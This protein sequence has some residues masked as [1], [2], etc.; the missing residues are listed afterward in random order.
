MADLEEAVRRAIERV[1]RDTESAKEW[2]EDATDP[3]RERAER[4]KE[5]I[6]EQ[7]EPV[8]ERVDDIVDDIVEE[9][10][11][12]YHDIGVPAPWE[13]PEIVRDWLRRSDLGDELEKL[14]DILDLPPP[15]E[16]DE[17]D[18]D[19]E[20]DDDDWDIFDWLVLAWLLDELIEWLE[21][22]HDLFSIDV[23]FVVFTWEPDPPEDEEETVIEVKR[24]F[25]FAPVP[26]AARLLDPM[27]HGGVAFPG[28]GS[29]DVLIGGLPALRMIDQIACPMQ[30][31]IPHT[32]SVFVP[33]IQQVF[34][35]GLPALRAGD[36]MV[37]GLGGPNPIVTGC[38]TVIIGQPVP[39]VECLEYEEKTI[40]KKNRELWRWKKI[41]YGKVKGK[42]YIG[43]NAFGPYAR[44][45]GDVELAHLYAETTPE[46]SEYVKV[47]AEAIL[48]KAHVKAKLSKPWKGRPKFE[49]D[50]SDLELGEVETEVDVELPWE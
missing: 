12:R 47:D 30:A 28:P 35:N 7:T 42:I 11:D 14:E 32:P 25:F 8:R 2:L 43:L 49:Y 6:E 24:F 44:F 23:D 22:D 34:I 39:P 38:P 36:F 5:W 19:D 9:W 10:E 18:E 15:E 33:S 4:G 37:E 21:A 45:E 46:F 3:V 16:D 41:E 26:F 48:G 13:V 29:P 31:P 20:E 17:D 40:T 50:V 1:Q 27:V